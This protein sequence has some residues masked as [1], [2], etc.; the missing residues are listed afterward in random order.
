[1]VC[2]RAPH[3]RNGDPWKNSIPSCNWKIG[4]TGREEY[5]AFWVKCMNVLNMNSGSVCW[6]GIVGVCKCVII[7][8]GSLRWWEWKAFWDYIIE[9]V[10]NKISQ[11]G[12]KIIK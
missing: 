6:I 11:Y 4:M 7:K 3:T 10:K 2:A 8:M 1:M 12:I 5:P 9:A